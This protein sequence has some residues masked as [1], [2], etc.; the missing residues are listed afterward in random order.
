M[1]VLRIAL[2]SI[3][4][5]VCSNV[6]A[7]PI[8]TFYTPTL[9]GFGGSVQYEFNFN[10]ANNDLSLLWSELD[11]LNYALN[12]GSWASATVVNDPSTVG[13][14]FAFNINSSSELFS[15]SKGLILVN[16]SVA[17][18]TWQLGSRSQ[19]GTSMLAQRSCYYNGCQLVSVA[20]INAASTN[21]P[22]PS[23]IA[24]L[25]LGFLGLAARRLK[26]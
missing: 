24:I 9:T 10:D 26:K 2:I 8:Y 4:L 11:S 15:F 1:N 5:L 22:E 13:P 21:V 14:G 12:G 23:S 20:D 25:A 16:G 6:Y 17:G 18:T 19:G 3:V 7:S